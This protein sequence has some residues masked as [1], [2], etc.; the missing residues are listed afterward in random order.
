[1]AT[2]CCGEATPLQVEF[3]AGE[4]AAGM[5][6]TMVWE[7]DDIGVKAELFIDLEGTAKAT[8]AGPSGGE[9]SHQL[10]TRSQH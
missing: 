4:L 10:V 2:P 7:T 6:V 5:R 9:I 1:M 3:P 8:L